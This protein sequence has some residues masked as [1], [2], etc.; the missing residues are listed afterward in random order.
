MGHGNA[1]EIWRC[2]YDGLEPA[3]GKRTKA[4]RTSPWV[5]STGVRQTGLPRTAKPAEQSA[6]PS[7]RHQREIHSLVTEGCGLILYPR[8]TAIGARPDRGKCREFQGTA[9]HADSARCRILIRLGQTRMAIYEI[10]EHRVSD[11]ATWAINT[12]NTL[13]TLK[14]GD[15]VNC[16]P[17]LDS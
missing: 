1:N 10:G 17:T 9:T 12:V 5:K 11:R 2:M 8:T 16:Q 14:Q 3:A 13:R 7:E 6:P 4:L 15:L